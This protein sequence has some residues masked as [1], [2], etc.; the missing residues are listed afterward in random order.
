M[1]H[2]VYAVFG[3]GIVALGLLHVLSM[4]RNLTPHALWFASGGLAMILTGALNLLNRVY[5]TGA[6]GLHWACV[7]ANVI[8]VAFASLFGVVSRVTAGQFVSVVGLFVGAT[9]C[10]L[11]RRAWCS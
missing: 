8:M 5:G 11:S 1:M 6:S 9:I 10:S 2:R 4:P 7:G 3:S